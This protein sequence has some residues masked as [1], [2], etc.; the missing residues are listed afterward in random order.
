MT[1]A[2]NEHTGKMKILLVLLLL[3]LFLQEHFKNVQEQV[4]TQISDV[5]GSDEEDFVE[6][7]SSLK[8]TK[9]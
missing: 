2:R 5:L 1:N 4:V 6:Y 7:S 3:F 9:H 8:T